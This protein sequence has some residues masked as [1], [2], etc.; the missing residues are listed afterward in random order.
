VEEAF[1][2]QSVTLVL[3]HDVDVSRGRHAGRPRSPAGH[4]APIC[5]RKVCWMHPRA[6]ATGP[7][8]PAQAHDHTVQ[9]VV[10][11]IEHR[12]D[13]ATLRAGT[14]ARRARVE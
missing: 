3:A 12:L 7:E 2:P 11:G 5:T 13:I 1:C 14:R 6:A 8:V 10:T 9:A 4:A